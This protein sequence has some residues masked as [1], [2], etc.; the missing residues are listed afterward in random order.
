MRAPRK[1]VN[2]LVKPSLVSS[3]RILGLAAG[4]VVF[5]A[6][7]VFFSTPAQLETPVASVAPSQIEPVHGSPEPTLFETLSLKLSN[8]KGVESLEKDG[9]AGQVKVTLNSDDF[10]MIGSAHL[11]ERSD[12]A[13][14]Q[15]AGMVKQVFAGSSIEIEGHTDDSPVIKQK[16]LYRSNWELSA[17]R[18]STMV[19]VFEGVGFLKNHLKVIGFGDSRPLVPNRTDSGQA[20]EEN[21]VR[22]R[23]IVLR[24]IPAFDEGRLKQ[25]L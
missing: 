5:G 14:Q 13:L 15:L 4:C 1:R 23:R 7:G 10:F 24:V 6:V 18:A 8:L 17:A 22:N 9:S 3:R 21:L 20:I 11:Q 12:E 25:G 19:H 2:F 16:K